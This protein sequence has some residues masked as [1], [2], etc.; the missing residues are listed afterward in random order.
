MDEET[1]LVR[2]AVA[3]PFEGAAGTRFVFGA[4][5]YFFGVVVSAG[6]FGIAVRWIESPLRALV[7]IAVGLLALLPIFGYVAATMRAVLDEG[8][9]PPTFGDPGTLVRDGR[10]VALVVLAYLVPLAIAAGGALVLSEDGALGVASLSLLGVGVAYS[11]VAAYVLPAAVVSVVH[12]GEASAAWG[13]GTLREAVDD[14]RYASGWAV[15]ALLALV[16][17]AIGVISAPF[18]VGFAVLFATQVAAT[19]AVTRGVIGALDLALEDPPAPP[20][21]GYVAGWDDG[22]RRKELSQGRLGGSLLPTTPGDDADGSDIDRSEPSGPSGPLAPTSDGSDA[23]SE[24]DRASDASSAGEAAAGDE[25]DQ[26]SSPVEG[27]SDIAP[28][29]EGDGDIDTRSDERDA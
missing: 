2:S 8:S 15:G 16:G 25:S 19:Y 24:A 10:R 5:L 13:F 14:H 29:V 11:L 4:V 27:G 9:E 12:A 1:G 18:V 17:G 22:P 21:S 6:A 26:E 28:F 3:Y 7:V 23:T 20:A